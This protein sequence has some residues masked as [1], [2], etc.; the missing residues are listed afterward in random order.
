M[1][2]K[3]DNALQKALDG[4]GK[5]PNKL[6]MTLEKTNDDRVKVQHNYFGGSDPQDSEEYSQDQAG[7]HAHI[8]QHIFGK[9]PKKTPKE[10][11]S[12]KD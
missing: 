11:P 4:L 3:A 7:L 10:P 8:D 9:K 2:Q 6:R 1:I 12:L 5:K